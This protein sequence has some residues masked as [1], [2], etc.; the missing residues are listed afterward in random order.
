MGLYRLVLFFILSFACFVA[1]FFLGQNYD[2][3]QGLQ[4]SWQQTEDIEQDA[5][6]IVNGEIDFEA[7]KKLRESKADKDGSNL[8]RDSNKKF[9]A[10]AEISNESHT[11]SLGDIEYYR[12]KEFLKKLEEKTKN[13]MKQENMFVKHE[14]I[15]KP[16]Q[17]KLEEKTNKK[18]QE[19]D[20]KNKEYNKVNRARLL[21]ISKQQTDF[22]LN[23]EYSFLVNVFSGEKKALEYIEKL[24][25]KYPLWNF[26]IKLHKGNIKIYLGP[27]TSREKALNFMR[28]A[29]TPPPF[30]NYFLEQQAL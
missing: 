5:C 22:V 30:P 23:G 16:L 20:Q 2:P 21:S 3:S 13:Q 9:G 28:L 26:F 14:D 19:L 4:W 1:G 7:C 17:E 25:N 10:S 27:F 12:N 29:P 15:D 6:K 24:Q 11:N 8:L 18:K